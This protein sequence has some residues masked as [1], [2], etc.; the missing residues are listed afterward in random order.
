MFLFLFLMNIS[1]GADLECCHFVIIAMVIIKTSSLNP[2]VSKLAS[3]EGDWQDLVKR[4]GWECHEHQTNTP[5][6]TCLPPRPLH[7]PPEGPPPCPLLFLTFSV[8]STLSIFTS[9]PWEKLVPRTQVLKNS[10]K[11]RKEENFQKKTSPLLQPRNLPWPTFGEQLAAEHLF[12]N[13]LVWKCNQ[14]LST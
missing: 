12:S 8:S 1:A 7:R 13:F 6:P 9:N 4:E 3:I 5:P 11:D 2:H 10:L 14:N